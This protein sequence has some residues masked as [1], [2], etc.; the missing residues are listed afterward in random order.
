M[1]IIVRTTLTA[2]VL[3][4]IPNFGSSQIW[5]GDISNNGIVNGIDWLYLGAAFNQNG[6]ARPEVS[7]IWLSHNEPAFWEIDFPEGHNYFHADCNGD[8]VVNELDAQVINDNFRLSRQGLLPE[9]ISQ[10]RLGKDPTL[11]FAQQRKDT[12]EVQAGQILN[13]P[14]SLENEEIP[15]DNFYGIRFKLNV[16]DSLIQDNISITESV[17]T[18]IDSTIIR[19]ENFTNVSEELDFAI[20]RFNRENESG[21]GVMLTMSLVIEENLI[22]VKDPAKVYPLWVDSLKMVDNQLNTLN[23]VGDT[24]YFKVISDITNPTSVFP[25]TLN[26]E[27]TKIFPNPIAG[28]TVFIESLDHSFS[29]FQLVT[30][31]GQVLYSSRLDISSNNVQ[32]I[33]LPQQN[34]PEGIYWIK[35]FNDK[36]IL[37]KKIILKGD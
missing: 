31:N 25:S 17:D 11:F 15:I 19:R 3:L 18:W 7:S 6:P 29:R 9:E 14:I 28:T 30:M 13:I 22:F 21:S 20:T 37:T 8:G 33:N 5:P 16:P 26:S 2:I 32:R 12:I 35:L 34:F 10:G 1:K 23:V 24:L 36:G 27:N 4:M